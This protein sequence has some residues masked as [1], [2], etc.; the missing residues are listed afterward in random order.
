MHNFVAFQWEFVITVGINIQA[1]TSYNKIE[2]HMDY[3]HLGNSL[4]Y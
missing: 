2:C 3:A 4:K 1:H